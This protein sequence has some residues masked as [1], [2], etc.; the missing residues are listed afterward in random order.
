MA[1]KKMAAQPLER[2]AQAPPGYLLTASKLVQT[3][4]QLVQH[5]HQI[6]MELKKAVSVQK[7]SI[8]KI[9]ER[10][11]RLFLDSIP[12]LVV[13]LGTDQR[14]TF[15]NKRFAAFV[16]MTRRQTIG[17]EFWATV[18]TDY[19]S[20]RPRLAEAMNGRA[21]TYEQSVQGVEERYFH[22]T[23][24]PDFGLSDN[25]DGVFISLLDITER[26]ALEEKQRRNVKSREDVLA[27]VS[28]D[29]KSP[30]MVVGLVAKVLRQP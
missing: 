27:V 8:E 17:K 13:H 2:Q 24:A 3:A 21:V 9:G 16:G 14:V 28:H 7:Q 1:K 5:E 18:P 19:D 11:F 4:S 20:I 30:V 29:L 22:I 6:L 15:C 23:I 10:R 25:V 12:S 26:K